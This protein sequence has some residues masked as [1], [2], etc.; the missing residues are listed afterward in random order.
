MT[1]EQLRPP[2]GFKLNLGSGRVKKRE[3]RPK[4]PLY[5]SFLRTRAKLEPEKGSW[6]C[7]P[8]KIAYKGPVQV[9]PEVAVRQSVNG[10]YPDKI[11]Q[12]AV[13][14]YWFGTSSQAIAS[15]Q[16]LREDM[17]YAS[18]HKAAEQLRTSIA[19]VDQLYKTGEG[20]LQADD[21]ERAA[22]P[23]DEA[24][25][26]DQTLMGDQAIQRPSFYRRSI[27]ADMASAAY[28]RGKAYSD[29]QDIRHGCAIF[30]LGLRF[31]GGN[32]DLN[33]IASACSELASRKLSEAENCK[34]LDS[35]VELAMDGDGI[36]E[37]SLPQ[38]QQLK[39][40]PLTKAPQAPNP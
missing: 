17:R 16:R 34:D 31:F 28:T 10:R 29:R 4:D 32:L 35:A 30:R 27:Q 24:L 38:R 18:V 14:G 23:F 9:K 6:Q 26:T 37:R 40:P 3:W 12:E 25:Q 11:M 15:L 1:T 19:S 22:D 20:A 5:L 21:P 39:C 13:M 2:V 7:P 8:L 36:K 33:R